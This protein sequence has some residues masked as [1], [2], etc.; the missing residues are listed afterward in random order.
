[1]TFYNFVWAWTTIAIIVF[2]ILIYFKIK[3]PYGRHTSNK[4]GPVIDNKWGWFWMEL[5][6]FLLMP[7][8]ALLGLVETDLTYLLVFY[9]HTIIFRTFVF[10]SD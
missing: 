4:W 2:L 7:L 6:A 8:L 9:G 3:A 10:L 1:M 5:P